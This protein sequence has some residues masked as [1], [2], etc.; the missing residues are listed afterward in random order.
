MSITLNQANRV[1]RATLAKAAGSSTSRSPRRSST[2]AAGLVALQRMRRGA[3][4]AGV[5]GSQGEGDRLRRV[6]NRPSGGQRRR[7]RPTS[8]PRAASPPPR[9]TT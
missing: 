7:A 6:P 1:L 2:M 8:R 5:Y 3:I 4:W 9:A